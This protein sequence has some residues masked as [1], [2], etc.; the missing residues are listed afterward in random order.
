MPLL[1]RR[2]LALLL[3]SFIAVAAC[4]KNPMDADDDDDDDDN[5]GGPLPSASNNLVYI[6]PANSGIVATLDV[7]TGAVRV[8]GNANQA[9]T[10]IALDPS[11]NLFGMTFNQLFRVNTS[12]AA[13]TLVG[14]HTVPGG[15]GLTFASNGTLYASGAFG[16]TLHTINPTTAATTTLGTVSGISSGDLA[17]HDGSLYFS[18][19]G[20]NST[21]FLIRVN[22]SNVSASTFV[23]PFGVPRMFG[24]ISKGGVLYGASDTTLYT[25]NPTTA[26]VSSPVSFANKGLVDAG[27]MALRLR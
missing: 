3:V 27:G 13:A 24:L 1:S 26:A 10:D 9:F 8:I 7:K 22:L 16:L 25:I 6:H 14:T 18:V 2:F 21:D 4:G 15:N 23:G 17:F 19:Q 5:G 12:T 20:D 11:G